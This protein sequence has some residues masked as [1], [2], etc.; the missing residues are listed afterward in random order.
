[1]ITALALSVDQD[2]SL[3]NVGFYSVVGQR[4]AGAWLAWMITV[5]AI[6]SQIGLA[7]GFVPDSFA[8]RA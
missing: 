6:F 3:F 8:P 5:G 1:M 2:V 7:N 4:V